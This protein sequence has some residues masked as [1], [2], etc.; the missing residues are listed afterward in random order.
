MVNGVKS[1]AKK[2]K[3]FSLAARTEAGGFA[4]TSGTPAIMAAPTTVSPIQTIEQAPTTQTVVTDRAGREIIFTSEGRLFLKT[5]EGGK[6]FVNQQ[7]V[8]TGQVQTRSIERVEAAVEA[9]R[10]ISTRRITTVRELTPEAQR[11][12]ILGESRLKEIERKTAPRAFMPGVTP[13]EERTRRRIEEQAREAELKRL[14]EEGKKIKVSRRKITKR[15]ALR[16]I[17]EGPKPEGIL[18]ELFPQIA[19]S[20][21]ERKIDKIPGVTNIRTILGITTEATFKVGQ[22]VQVIGSFG[23][24]RKSPLVDDKFLRRDAI[25]PTKEVDLLARNIRDR[26]LGGSVTNQEIRQLKTQITDANLP[27]FTNE[28]DRRGL[29]GAERDKFI[30]EGVKN[31]IL[32]QSQNFFLDR[33]LSIQ[34]SKERALDVSKQKLEAEVKLTQPLQK[35]EFLKDSKIGTRISRFSPKAILFN[36]N[37]LALANQDP[38]LIKVVREEAS[39]IADK[40]GLSGSNKSK[41][42]ETLMQAYFARAQGKIGQDLAAEILSEAAAAGIIGNLAAKGFTFA[43]RAGKVKFAKEVTKRVI[44]FAALEGF[45]QSKLKGTITGEKTGDIEIAKDVALGTATGTTFAF[46]LGFFQ[47]GRILDVGKGQGGK[48][49]LTRATGSVLDLPEFPAD[50]TTDFSRF[51]VKKTTGV[52]FQPSVAVKGLKN[53]PV[54]AFTTVPAE[55]LGAS[56]KPGK[57]GGQFKTTIGVLPQTQQPINI[58]GKP[59][60]ISALVDIPSQKEPS[61]VIGREGITTSTSIGVPAE[62]TTQQQNIQDVIDNIIGDTTVP[63]Q[64]KITIP[65]ETKITNIL[66]VPT[67]VFTPILKAPPPILPPAFPPSSSGRGGAFTGKGKKFVRELEFS[68]KILQESIL[69]LTP[70]AKPKKAAK[71]K[72]GKKKRRISSPK[73][74][75]PFSF[76]GI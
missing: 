8:P 70:F 76:L 22:G 12:L 13:A 60:P 47:A 6:I 23:E 7:G 2:I 41:R 27:V 73:V 53:V 62:T 61:V 35:L 5:V 69:G 45:V 57:I 24:R 64:T 43:G 71:P 16:F 11:E 33:G 67:T 63:T 30:S 3:P 65:A 29:T 44:P 75:D 10:D 50:V 34:E 9:P 40:E 19:E 32:I 59:G 26:V 68:S 46:G 49:F 28:A 1:E 4:I 55:T 25:R 15:E 52:G 17:K 58:N 39:E 56:P 51:L 38:N 72:K 37:P 21:K 18:S 54:F 31:E 42:V 14:A 66:T 48:A 36:I 74:F 20:Q